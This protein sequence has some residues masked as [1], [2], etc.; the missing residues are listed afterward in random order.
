MTQEKMNKYKQNLVES[1]YMGDH[2]TM[3]DVI[4]TNLLNKEFMGKRWKQGWGYY[5]DEQLI[6]ITSGLSSVEVCIPYK[7]IKNMKKCNQFFLPL[8]INISYMDPKNEEIIAVT[9]STS[10]RQ[11]YLDILESKSG[12][13][14]E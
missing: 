3:L 2:E 10:K 12:V 5:T 4:Q 11:K 14:A 8:G 9:I 1:G 6:V 13:K 7:N